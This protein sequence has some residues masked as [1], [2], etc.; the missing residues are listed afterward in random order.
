[1]LED[2]ER[3]KLES[4]GFRLPP[5]SYTEKCFPWYRM[6]SL[7]EGAAVYADFCTTVVEHVNEGLTELAHTSQACESGV[8]T[9]RPDNAHGSVR[10]P[11]KKWLMTMLVSACSVVSKAS[12]ITHTSIIDGADR[13]LSC[14]SNHDLFLP[15]A[16]VAT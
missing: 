4:L 5:K 13:A 8:N 15:S 3:S 16:S 10:R 12:I 6:P 1:M 11:W 14:H 7:D 9:E 2:L